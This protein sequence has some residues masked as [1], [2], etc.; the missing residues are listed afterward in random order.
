MAR[1]WD[2]YVQVAIDMGP[3]ALLRVIGRASD[4]DSDGNGGWVDVLVS[5]LRAQPL[6][7]NTF[8]HMGIQ[9]ERS[10][11]YSPSQHSFSATGGDHGYAIIALK[12]T[13]KPPDRRILAVSHC[14][15]LMWTV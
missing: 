12:S 8:R 7:Q 9:F 4:D 2:A 3:S 6:D 13:G 14:N 10:G 5:T 15:S 11:R 1:V